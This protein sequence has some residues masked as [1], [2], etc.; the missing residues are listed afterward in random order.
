M[1]I[2]SPGVEALEPGFDREV[3]GAA[4]F[5]TDRGARAA[6]GVPFTGDAGLSANGSGLL[7]DLIS[8]GDFGSV[9]ADGRFFFSGMPVEIIPSVGGC[10]QLASSIALQCRTARVGCPFRGD[11]GRQAVR[12]S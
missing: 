2:D 1:N 6:F 10:D 11:P 4:R 7:S 12:E 8:D 9:L 5:E 3:F